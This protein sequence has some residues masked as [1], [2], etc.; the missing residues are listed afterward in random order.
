MFLSFLN[1]NPIG[2][3]EGNNNT[4]KKRESNGYCLLFVILPTLLHLLFVFFYSS[5]LEKKM[6]RAIAFLFVYALERFVI[7]SLRAFFF[8]A[9]ESQLVHTIELIDPSSKSKANL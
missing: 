4:K 7:T 1:A 2:K 8:L 5:K 9:N 3:E 6:K